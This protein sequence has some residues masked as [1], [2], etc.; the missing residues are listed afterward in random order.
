MNTPQWV[1]WAVVLAV[2]LAVIGLVGLIV[3]ELLRRSRK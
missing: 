1:E 3:S 2:I